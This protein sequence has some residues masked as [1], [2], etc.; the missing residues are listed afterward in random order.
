MSTRDSPSGRIL[1]RLE[2][3]PG[4]EP[5][6]TGWQ[7]D[8]LPL[9]HGLVKMVGVIRFERMTCRSQ[10]ERATKLRHT[11]MMPPLQGAWGLQEWPWW[12]SVHPGPS[13]TLI[14]LV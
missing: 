1:N 5:G 10:S 9:D 6:Q 3:P 11:P 2:R 14:F 7:P 13:H 8:V 4:L 12:L